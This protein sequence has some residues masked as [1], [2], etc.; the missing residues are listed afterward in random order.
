MTMTSQ[1]TKKSESLEMTETSATPTKNHSV[2]LIMSQKKIDIIKGEIS[3]QN[4]QKMKN[5]T[6]M[7][8][9]KINLVILLVN[10]C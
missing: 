10:L 1:N 4:L 3:T 9:K 6:I 2:Q 7:K 5:L 8:L